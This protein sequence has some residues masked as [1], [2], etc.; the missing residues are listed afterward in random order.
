MPA[1]VVDGHDFFAVHEAAGEAIERARAGKGPSFIECQ[2]NR[3]YG[4]FEGDA[5]TYRPPGEVEEVRANRD[6][7]EL[8]ATQVTKSAGIDSAALGEIDRKVATL[9]EESVVAAKSDPV[10][11]AEELLTDVYISY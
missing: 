5:Q 11:S 9:I 2:V 1:V 6:C 7:L 3:Y 8:F 4:H 10:P